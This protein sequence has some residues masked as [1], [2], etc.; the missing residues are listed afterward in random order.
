ML[1]KMLSSYLESGY[2]D[3]RGLMRLGAFRDITIKTEVAG[4]II[5]M[6]PRNYVK[7]I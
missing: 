4:E 5:L 2:W 1:S 3:G 6:Y 7:Q